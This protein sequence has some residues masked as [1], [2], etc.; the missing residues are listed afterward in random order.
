MLIRNDSATTRL[1]AIA[2]LAVAMWGIIQASINATQQEINASL[3]LRIESLEE[4]W[5]R[6]HN[7]RNPQIFPRH[8][9]EGRMRMLPAMSK[10]PA[11]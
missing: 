11:E 2:L 4:A 9:R 5:R 8:P 1:M 3:M 6:D 10:E 7:I